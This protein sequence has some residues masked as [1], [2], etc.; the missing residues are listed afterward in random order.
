MSGR[1]T[2]STT[3]HRLHWMVVSYETWCRL[4]LG[5]NTCPF[6]KRKLTRRQ[7]VK[8]TPENIDEYRSKMVETCHMPDNQGDRT[9]TPLHL[10]AAAP[11][12]PHWLAPVRGGK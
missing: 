2:S 5:K 10:H 9:C 7:L 4:L 8:L 11:A 3:Q 12:R 1:S 6:T